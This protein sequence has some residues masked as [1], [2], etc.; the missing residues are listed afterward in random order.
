[1]GDSI[2]C[3]SAASA[4]NE[5]KNFEVDFYTKWPQ[6]KSLLDFDDRF[7]TILYKD[8]LVGQILLKISYLTMI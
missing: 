3:A 1:M 4:L 5:E 6:L 2:V 8:N 7:N